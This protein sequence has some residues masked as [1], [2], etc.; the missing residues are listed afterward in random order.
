CGGVAG[1]ELALAAH[2]RLGPGA[3]VTVIEADGALALIGRGARRALLAHLDRAGIALRE[4]AR[5]VAVEPG[6]VRLEGG[7]R[8]DAAFVLGAAAT[9]PQE[10]LAETGLALSDGFVTV[11][12]SLQSVT[13]PA[14]FAAGDIAHMGFAPRPKA[15]VYAVRQAPVLLHNLGVALTGQ[16]RMR[17]YRPQQDYLKLISTGSKGAVADKWGLPLDG[18]W[19]WRWKDRIDRRFMAMFHQLPRMPALAV[20]ARVAAGVAEELASAKPLCGGCG[21]K[22]GQA[23]LKAALAHLPRPARPDVLSG[24]GDDAAILTHGKGHQVLTT[25]H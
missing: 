5:A 15:G 13:D 3:E 7:E 17:A 2:H 6:A 10:W 19:L 14:V 18:A 8:V 23:E 1:V 11:G 12:P 24:P 25:D 20:P 16:R 9:R 4:G 22:V 21:A